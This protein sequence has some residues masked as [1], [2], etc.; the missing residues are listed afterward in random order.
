VNVSSRGMPTLED[1]LNEQDEED[2]IELEMLE[3]E[4]EQV[5]K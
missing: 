4:F 3:K 2:L 5:I 1:W